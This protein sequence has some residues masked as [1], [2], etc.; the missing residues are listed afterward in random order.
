[1]T[2]RRVALVNVPSPTHSCISSSWTQHANSFYLSRLNPPR[3]DDDT[4]STCRATLALTLSSPVSRRQRQQYRPNP[5]LSRPH[6]PHND[7]VTRTRTLTRPHSL[8]SSQRHD[9]DA[10][11]ARRMRHRGHD[12]DDDVACHTRQ[13]K[14]TRTTYVHCKPNNF[15]F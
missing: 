10:M 5:I 2:Q 15:F 7:D 6:Q 11:A 9:V 13:P 8:P 4:M 3:N 14:R 12:D 1:M